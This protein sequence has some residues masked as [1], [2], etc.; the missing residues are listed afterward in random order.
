[1]KTASLTQNINYGKT[2]PTITVLIESES[3]KEIRIALKKGQKM[4][5]H[6][7]PYPIVVEIFKGKI[8]FGINGE[9][10]TL[11]EGGIISLS[12]NV[13]HNLTATKDSI[14]RLSL[15]LKDKVERVRSVETEYVGQ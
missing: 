10:F 4:K 14:V 12:G 6:K 8:D 15:S 2:K 9:I 11:E 5:E 7:T 1:M 13:P 3:T